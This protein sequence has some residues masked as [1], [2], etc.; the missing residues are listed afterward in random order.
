MLNW[1]V[2]YYRGGYFSDD[3]IALFVQVGMMTK[4]DY[5]LALTYKAEHDVNYAAFAK[6][7]QADQYPSN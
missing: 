3:D 7:A 2:S 5:D 4:S 6:Q 1:M